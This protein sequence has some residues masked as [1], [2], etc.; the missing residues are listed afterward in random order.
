MAVR[1]VRP[2][3]KPHSRAAKVRN[4]IKTAMSRNYID[5]QRELAG[6]ANMPEATLSD[7]ING[8]TDVSLSD[9]WLFHTVLKFT[10]DEWLRLRDC[11]GR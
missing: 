6:L 7:K 10:D 4:V 5:T 11:G 1:K 3:C 9:L 2:P 8:R